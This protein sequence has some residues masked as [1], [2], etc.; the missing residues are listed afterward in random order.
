MS[1]YK[2]Y[3][4][5]TTA[6]KVYETK[7]WIFSYLIHENVFMITNVFV[8]LGKR[9]GRTGVVMRGKI[10]EFATKHGCTVI[11]GEVNVLNPN[12]SSIIPLLEK[13]G[14]KI[15]KT[16]NNKTLVCKEI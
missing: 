1:L 10:F 16:Y 5:E 7:D 2:S 14:C 6:E 4:E 9:K 13:N 15:V 11:S 12:Y 3:L 8:R